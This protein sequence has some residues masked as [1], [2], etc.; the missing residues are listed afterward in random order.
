MRQPSALSIACAAALLVGQ[1]VA[2]AHTEFSG[3]M[4]ADL[5]RLAHSDDA[6]DDKKSSTGLDVKRFYLGISHDLDNVWS[7]HLITDFQYLKDD[8]ISNV[9]VKKAYLQGKLHDAA[10]LRVGAA[11]MPWVPFVDGWYGFRYVESTLVDRLKFGTSTDWG[12]HMGGTAG[13]S[14]RLGYAISAANG[15]GYRHPDR[16]GSVDIEARL[17]FQPADGVVLGVGGYS[18]KLGQ[19]RHGGQTL[20]TATRAN[21]MVAWKNEH[22]RIGGEYFS[23]RNWNQVMSHAHDRSDG[24]SLWASHQVADKVTLFARHDDARPSRG[25]DPAARKRYSHIGV[26]YL[27]IPGFKLAAVYKNSRDERSGVAQAPAAAS[28]RRIEEVG[29]WAEVRF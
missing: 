27:V 24:W 25:I 17:S 12:L 19:G 13:A 26:E 2:H 28:T 11:D 1:G 29:L 20:Q 14:R 15:A 22:T 21:A 8:G 7:A 23:A 5:T 10:T 16:S 18:G 3:R 6:T 4:Y 9:F